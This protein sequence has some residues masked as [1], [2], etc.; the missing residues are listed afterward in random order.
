[1]RKLSGFVL[2]FLLIAFALP[3]ACGAPTQ[4]RDAAPLGQ[5]FWVDVGGLK[6][7]GDVPTVVRFKRVVS[8]S[9]CPTDALVLCASAGNARLEFTIASQVG[10]ETVFELNTLPEF[11]PSV[12]EQ[13]GLRIELLTVMPGARLEPPIQPGEYRARLVVSAP[14]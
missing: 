11:G 7:I 12:V 8:D 3:S 6:V 4:V 2:A 14:D 9:R 5:P 1:M 10:D 13:A